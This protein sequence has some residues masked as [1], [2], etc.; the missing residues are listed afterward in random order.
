MHWFIHL[1]IYLFIYLFIHSFVFFNSFLFYLFIY[2]FI[3]YTSIYL[4]I[5][6][7]NHKLM[8]LL[9]EYLHEFW[10]N[11]HVRKDSWISDLRMTSNQHC[12][13]NSASWVWPITVFFLYNSG[14]LTFETV[15]GATS[16]FG[17]LLKMA[18]IL[19]GATNH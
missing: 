15:L 4:F 6:L 1:F 14:L 5:C 18:I 19:H 17:F 11:C 7:F 9:I 8:L 13:N 2:F 16:F 12:L 10:R 3:Y